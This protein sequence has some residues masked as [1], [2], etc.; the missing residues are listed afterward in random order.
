MRFH[1]N[2]WIVAV[3][4][5]TAVFAAEP[6]S[7]TSSSSVYLWA[8]KYVYQPGQQATVRWTV[9]TNGDNNLYT[10]F[11]YRTNNQ[12]G[13]RTYF[14][15]G[16]T[17]PTDMYGNAT[18]FRP[19]RLA[20][21]EK[22]VLVGN[23]G[24]F[25]AAVGALPQ[26]LGMHTFTVQLRDYTG[27]R[28][29]KTKYFKVGVVDGV[30]TLTGTIDSNR[31]LTNN[32]SYNISGVVQVRG[33]ATLTIE[34]GTILIGQ[35]GSQPP[36]MLLITNTGKIMAEGTRTRPIIMTSS[37]AFGQRAP[38]DWGGLV[39]LGKAPVNW[40]NGTGNI[41]GLPPGEETTYGGTDPNHDCGSIKYVRVEY[42]GAELR[43]NDEINS[44][45]WGGCGK[46]TKAS[47][48]QAHYGLDDAFEWFG[49]NNDAKYLVSTYAAD[50]HIDVQIGYTGRLQHILAVANDD[51]SNRGI[52]SDNNERDFG[53]QP[54][55]VLHAYNMT[56]VGSSVATRDEG[57][58]VAGVWLRRGSVAD[59]N[60]LLVYNWYQQAFSVS[61]NET[62]ANIDN[63]T[64]KTNGVLMWDNG[65]NANKPNTL[66]GQ[67]AESV[68][69]YAQGTRG[70]GRNF[71]VANPALRKPLDRS[72][73]DF[74]PLAGSPVFN[75]N[76]V[77]PPDDGFYDQWARWI[78]AFG[79]EDWTEEWTNFLQEQDIKPN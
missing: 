4:L 78:G 16:N 19:V 38:G 39:M 31:T 75:L 42:S 57:T 13:E 54:P 59:L 40:P 32:K 43:P 8:D 51:G 12:T 18:N 33:G 79:D 28:V 66:A 52:E 60:N 29:I 24:V 49:G 48:L 37:V 15:A 7:Y 34:P 20:D 23:G 2:A 73:P 3:M 10:I 30:E 22:Q 35:P 58:S 1:N 25:P 63:G 50:D 36:S 11:V 47:F 17:T 53:A 55:G 26:E 62:F 14:P 76:W 27:S 68:L 65:K 72:D 77:Q 46:Q 70:Q 44:I 45:T 64:L 9:K 41:E 71:V 6:T 61:D 56:F 69:T 5:S 67:V 74:R 21:A